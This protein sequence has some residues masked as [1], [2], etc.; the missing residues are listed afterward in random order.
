MNG[1]VLFDDISNILGKGTIAKKTYK[2]EPM[3]LYWRV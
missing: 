2:K 3:T 1:I